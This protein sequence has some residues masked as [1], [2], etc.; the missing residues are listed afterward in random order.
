MA[1]SMVID[2]ETVN[3]V[4]AYAPQVG[5]SDEVKKSFW[6]ALDELVRECPPEQRLIIEGDLNGRIG[7]TV[8]EY[9]R[10]HKGFGYGTRNEEGRTIQEFATAHDLVVANS[11]FKKSDAHLITFQSGGHNT[12]IDY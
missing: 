2:G 8:D 7:A 12:Q 11:F 1:I 9:A 6:E 5:L 3:V 4:S 10:V